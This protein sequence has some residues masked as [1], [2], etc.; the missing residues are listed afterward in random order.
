MH[1]IRP[2]PLGFLGY[3]TGQWGA[4]PIIAV[5]KGEKTGIHIID[6]AEVAYARNVDDYNIRVNCLVSLV[7]LITG[8][9]NLSIALDVMPTRYLGGMGTT[10]LI[11][12]QHQTLYKS[13]QYPADI[14]IVVTP[15][16]WKPK[17][18][19]LDKTGRADK[20][21]YQPAVNQ[22]GL[23][24]PTADIYSPFWGWGSDR[25]EGH[26]MF[27]LQQ[28]WSEQGVR[29]ATMAFRAAQEY[30][31]DEKG[32]LFGKKILGRTPLG[33]DPDVKLMSSFSMTEE[34]TGN[35]FIGTGHKL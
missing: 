4:Q 31:I 14:A 9:S 32:A 20:E 11:P 21:L 25:R 33:L 29:N 16:G 8:K 34:F 15:Y 10:L 27:S 24:Y 1:G 7:C 5:P 6:K 30:C 35:G 22:I 2:L 17:H 18:H 12:D 28:Y 3:R 23:D 13:N 26:H 19:F